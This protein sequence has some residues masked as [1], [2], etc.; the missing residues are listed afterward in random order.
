M[1]DTGL[2]Q[3]GFLANYHA[4]V[5]PPQNQPLVRAIAATTGTDRYPKID[6][7]LQSGANKPWTCSLEGIEDSCSLFTTPNPLVAALA[8]NES[9]VLYLINVQTRCINEVPLS[10]PAAYAVPEFENERL[11]IATAIDVIAIGRGGF[12]WRSKRV[13]L[14]GI[15]MLNYA[16]G[17]VRGA[18]NE[19]GGKA[20]KFSINASNGLT[21]GGFDFNLTG[22]GYRFT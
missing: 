2:I 11:F 13:S 14:D 6:V 22:P 7:E 16:E 20:V 19:P 9:Y 5:I 21:S 3:G 17:Y 12:L 1:L 8:A 4:R 15:S 18:G 10:T